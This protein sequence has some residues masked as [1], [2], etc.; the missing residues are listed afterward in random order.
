LAGRRAMVSGSGSSVFVEV[1]DET[2]LTE[3]AADRLLSTARH[4]SIVRPVGHGPVDA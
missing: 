4:L 3:A 2:V 1:D